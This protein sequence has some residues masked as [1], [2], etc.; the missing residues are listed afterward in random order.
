MPQIL[1]LPD[2]KYKK[3]VDSAQALGQETCRRAADA[4]QKIAAADP[5]GSKRVVPNRRRDSHERDERRQEAPM[6]PSA[7]NGGMVDKMWAVLDRHFNLRENKVQRAV[8]NALIALD[9]HEFIIGELTKKSSAYIANADTLDFRQNDTK[10]DKKLLTH[11]V[12]DV[13][14]PDDRTVEKMRRWARHI[15][16]LGSALRGTLRHPG[17]SGCHAGAADGAGGV[18]EV[19]RVRAPGRP[20]GWRVPER[21]SEDW[22]FQPGD[23]A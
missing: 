4:I 18:D 2:N 3:F 7:T 9:E 19:F 5:E 22:A 13:S 1:L 16:E 11:G 12:V 10:S 23:C 8:A 6:V 21:E 15:G 17:G 14:F 20:R